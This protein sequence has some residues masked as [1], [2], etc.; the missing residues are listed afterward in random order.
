M[1]GSFLIDGFATIMDFCLRLI[2]YLNI[3]MRS[4]ACLVCVINFVQLNTFST[5][6]DIHRKR[7]RDYFKRPPISC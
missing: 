7:E 6:K 3:Q 2:N 5:G 4:P 1:I